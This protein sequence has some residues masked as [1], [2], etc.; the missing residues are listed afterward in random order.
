M[1]KGE[2]AGVTAQNEIPVK[3]GHK[4]EPG[5]ILFLLAVS[6]VLGLPMLLNG[7]LIDGHDSQEHL[8]YIKHFSEQFWH[9]DLYPRWLI[10]MNVGLG[11][12]S[13]FIY[14]PL[15][16]YVCVLLEPAAKVLHFNAFNVA[17]WLPLFGSGLTALLWLRTFV[18]KSIAA[19][20]AVLYMLMPYHLAIDMYRRCAIPECWAFAWMPLVLYFTLGVIAGKRRD[21]I[22]LAMTCALMIC[23]HLISLAIFAWIPLALALLLSRR[24]HRIRTAL[25]VVLAMGLGAAISSVYLLPALANAHF[26][27]VSRLLTRDSYHWNNNLL[28]LNR[29]LFIHYPQENFVQTVSWTVVSMIVIVA[30]C[31]FW[32]LLRGEPRSRVLVAFWILVCCFSVFMMSKRS[33]PIWHHVHPLYDA[34]QFPWRFNG[35]LCLGALPL[36][37]MCLSD[38]S[39]RRGIL[40][41]AFSSVFILVIA[42]WLFAYGNVWRRYKV[43]VGPGPKKE[44]YL[45]N[46]YDGWMNAWIPP[47]TSERAS[48]IA[49]SGPKAR[50]KE[51]AGTAQVLLWSPRHIQVET[52]SPT[53]GWVMVNQFYYPTWQAELI[54]QSKRAMIRPAM[55]EGLLEVQVPPGSQKMRVDIPVSALEYLGRLLSVL[56][57]L[58]CL[59]PSLAERVGKF[60]L[61]PETKPSHVSLNS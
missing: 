35:L 49:S 15:P 6:I 32:L 13:Y 61:G 42:G 24:G 18:S 9:G 26:I 4:I 16:A 36:I 40:R 52:N 23:S 28:F 60:A 55:P 14:P 5:P 19:A 43:D 39:H 34:V 25:S 41:A 59:V 11:S 31:G 44:A 22:A 7:P 45:V 47:G 56:G 1:Q 10:D 48:M 37:A 29:A 17:A 2:P 57:L 54:G 8:N 12:P 27:P 38:L 3:I 30:I 20:S 21:L 33:G 58:L 50:F 53:G 51:G 46:D